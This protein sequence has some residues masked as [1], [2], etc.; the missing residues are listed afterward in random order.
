MSYEIYFCRITLAIC[1]ELKSS[2]VSLCV[3]AHEA[4]VAALIW[5]PLCLLRS[6][7]AA[8]P[9]FHNFVEY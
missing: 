3:C 8:R 6:A 4:G 1:S 9:S 2:F 7:G 5:R